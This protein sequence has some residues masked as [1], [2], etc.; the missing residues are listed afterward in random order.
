MGLRI[1]DPGQL[2]LRRARA[3][4]R[5]RSRVEVWALRIAAVRGCTLTF[6][7]L[8]YAPHE[9]SED[10]MRR[11]APEPGGYWL[12]WPGGDETY[13]EPAEF[14]IGHQLVGYGRA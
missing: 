4:P 3:L 12:R 1:L 9:V 6:D 11:Y 2:Q 14:E 7:D 5:Y 13:A 8:C 10:F